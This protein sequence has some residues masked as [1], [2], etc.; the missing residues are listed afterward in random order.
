MKTIL[1]FQTAKNKNKKI[2]ML[3]CYDYSFAKIL[4]TTAIDTLLVGDSV[5]QVIHGHSTTLQATV[6]MMILHTSAV[7]KGASNKFIISD[8]PFLS[9]RK[10]IRHAVHA[11]GLL[12][13]A[14]AQAVKIEGAKGHQNLIQHLVE[15]GIPVIGHLGLTP[16]SIHQL[17]GPKIQGRNDKA[18]NEI[19]NDALILEKSGCFGLVLECIPAKLAKKITDAL[20]IPTIGI[21]AGADT[22]GQVLVLQDMLGLNPEFNPKFLKKY[23]N[24]FESVVSAI[25]HFVTDVEKNIFPT[26]KNSYE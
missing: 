2:T 13:Q 7:S 18:A 3:T 15:S 23:S 16:Q 10:G 26:D 22:S 8:M 12:M 21:G 4:N 6:E 9:T 11:A 24:S 20:I 14:G 17:G 25:D 5:A 19:L 1:D